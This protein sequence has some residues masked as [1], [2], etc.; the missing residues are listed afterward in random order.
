MKY[1]KFFNSA[2]IIIHQ[3]SKIVLVERGQEPFKGLIELPGGH[4]DAN[5]SVEQA[6]I[7]EAKEET[8]L[9]I[10]LENIFGVYS[11]P[12]RDPRGPT[13]TT[14][15]LAKPIGGKLKAGSDAKIG[16]WCDV[17]KIPFKKMAFD[18][19]EVL[20]DYLKWVKKKGTYWSTKT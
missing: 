20:R 8:N 17:K 9:K 14:V 4:V 16:F 7:R 6:A 10:K 15:F 19:S 12:G 18:H 2:D 3:W 5:E 1:E 13:I 11:A